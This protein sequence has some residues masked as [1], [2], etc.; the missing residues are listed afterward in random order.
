[1]FYTVVQKWGNKKMKGKENGKKIK[2]EW[3]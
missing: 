3:N 1:M 2:L